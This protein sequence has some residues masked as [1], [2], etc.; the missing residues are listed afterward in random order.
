ML[1]IDKPLSDIMIPF[2]FTAIYIIAAYNENHLCKGCDN[3]DA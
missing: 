1:L 2:L 3:T